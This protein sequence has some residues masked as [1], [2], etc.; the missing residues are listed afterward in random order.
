MKDRLSVWFPV[1]LVFLLALLTFW[2]DRMV[3]PPG[4]QKDGSQ[5]HDP[6][7]W[8]ENFTATRMG[9]DGTPQYV[10]V[11]GKMTHFPDDDSTHLVRPHLTRY[12]KDLPPMHIDSQIGQVS[13]DGEHAWFSGDVK[14]VREAGRGQ[15]ELTMATPWLHVI[16]DQDFAETNREVTVRNA[17]TRIAAVGME[18]NSKTRIIKF[19]SRVKGQHVKTK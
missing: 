14:V 10:L 2:L 7:Y 11:G 17:G 13:K 19:L 4:A 5:R 6:D 3:Q 15:S 12:A 1:G 16:P 9:P 8:V 18:F